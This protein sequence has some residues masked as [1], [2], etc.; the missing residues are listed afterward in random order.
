MSKCNRL[1]KIIANFCVAVLF[2]VVAGQV[3]AASESCSTVKLNGSSVWFPVS[4]R[5]EPAGGLRGVF[6]DLAGRIFDI[7]DI[8]LKSGPDLPWKRQLTLLENGQIDVLAGAYVTNERLQKFGVSRPVMKEDVAVFIRAG[9]PFRPQGPAELAGLRG[10]APFGASFGE[11]FDTFAEVNLAID[12]HPV[13]DLK[14]LIRLLIE[15][16]ADYMVSSRPGGE[17]LVGE[18]SA[19]GVVEVLPWPAAV[20]TLHFLFS[21]ATPC[22]DLLH[23]FNAELE[24]QIDAG[25][26]EDYT[27]IYGHGAGSRTPGNTNL[28]K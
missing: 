27:K 7:L 1:N 23:S 16:K 19:Y 8:R 22:I 9:L 14:T 18:M 26:L 4:I 5:E 12:R 11:E 25:K 10:V 13:D 17:R 2:N 21:R 28:N 24:R 6:P 20:N 15:D 3:H